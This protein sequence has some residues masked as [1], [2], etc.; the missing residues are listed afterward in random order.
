MFVDLYEGREEAVAFVKVEQFRHQ[1]V[2][3]KLGIRSKA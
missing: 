1:P 3:C 2:I